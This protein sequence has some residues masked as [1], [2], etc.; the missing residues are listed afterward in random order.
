MPDDRQVVID[1]AFSEVQGLLVSSSGVTTFKQAVH[2]PGFR[3][4]IRNKELEPL[5][6]TKSG[7]MY[8]S[9]KGEW[10]DRFAR[11]LSYSLYGVNIASGDYDVWELGPSRLHRRSLAI[12]LLDVGRGWT[13]EEDPDSAPLAKS[14]AAISELQE[15]ERSSFF[16]PAISLSEVSGRSV[17]LNCA[18]FFD[19]R[20]TWLDAEGGVREGD[21]PS[22]FSGC[23][24][25]DAGS[26]DSTGKRVGALAYDSRGIWRETGEFIDVV[27][28]IIRRYP[29]NISPGGDVFRTVR[30]VFVGQN[31]SGDGWIAVCHSSELSRERVQNHR[32]DASVLEDFIVAKV[33]VE[34]ELSFSARL[35]LAGEKGLGMQPI[36][37]GQAFAN[38]QGGRF[39]VWASGVV[40]RLSNTCE[41]LSVSDLR[42]FG[43]N[44]I[45]GEL[46]SGDF[47]C[48][49]AWGRETIRLLKIK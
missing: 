44:R 23:I 22:H 47:V 31:V 24:V 12:G 42:E 1:S 37:T 11:G 19:D 40:F 39:F 14:L 29:E 5:A 18:Q 16:Y 9:V 3:N 20:F 7:M 25:L 32:I 26:E 28:S 33:S 13:L 35:S 17:L 27:A 49:G 4:L 34:G 43:V 2:M 38:N 6:V 8:Y 36:A 15:L 10:S 48:S 45:L 21:F 41:L 30:L 46:D